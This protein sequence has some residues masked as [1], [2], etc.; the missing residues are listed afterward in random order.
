MEPPPTP[1]PLK[2]ASYTLKHPLIGASNGLREH[3]LACEQCLVI[4]LRAPTAVK[5]LLQAATTQC[6]CYGAPCAYPIVHTAPPKQ[7]QAELLKKD[8]Q[9]IWLFITE[10]Y[11]H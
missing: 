1:P 3:F 2:N 8:P 9:T 11:I 6:A 4:F 7:L 5:F 10:L